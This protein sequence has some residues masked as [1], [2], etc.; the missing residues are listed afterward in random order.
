MD[1]NDWLTAPAT[2][3]VAALI[4]GSND[5]FYDAL[6][7][8]KPFRP[9]VLCDRDF[10][11]ELA[12]MA[13]ARFHNA[14]AVELTRG[15]RRDLALLV[16]ARDT[17]P[18]FAP[19]AH[20]LK[21]V[22]LDVGKLQR[23]LEMTSGYDAP[24]RLTAED[25]LESFGHALGE[26]ARRSPRPIVIHDHADVFDL[27]SADYVTSFDGDP[28]P[29]HEASR[30]DAELFG[31]EP[32]RP[33]VDDIRAHAEFL[34]KGEMADLVAMHGFLRETPARRVVGYWRRNFSMLAED[35][36]LEALA[37]RATAVL[38]TLSGAEGG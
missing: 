38:E 29:D 9:I 27:R 2:G 36:G 19:S 7:E 28:A 10:A 6:L 14:P 5:A 25:T 11:S 33:E 8:A 13:N 37:M 30:V 4:G 3:G 21:S 12:A 31:E 23:Q 34:A 20:V 35:R 32:A 16:G 24:R 1:L 26:A 17:R 15:L 18:V 22:T